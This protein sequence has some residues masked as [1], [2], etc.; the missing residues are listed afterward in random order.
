MYDFIASLI[1]VCLLILSF[2][3][4]VTMYIA[5]LLN[6]LFKLPHPGPNDIQGPCW[7]RRNEGPCKYTFID[8]IKNLFR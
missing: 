1:I 3:K 5:H 6:N 8:F 4:N 7:C 2:N